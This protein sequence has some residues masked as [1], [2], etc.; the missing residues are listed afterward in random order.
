[1]SEKTRKRVEPCSRRPC[2][3]SV[4]IVTSRQAPAAFQ[5]SARSS[6]TWRM[7]SSAADLDAG[8]DTRAFLTVPSSADEDSSDWASNC[9]QAQGIGGGLV[10][11]AGRRQRTR[12]SGT[13]SVLAVVLLM[14][15]AVA[16]GPR[17]PHTDYVDALGRTGGQS[18][19]SNLG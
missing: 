8:A 17:R 1:M 4:P 10:E 16:C 5:A 13:A 2:S 6:G 9:S 14:T 11:L 3:S 19:E 7:A 12:R 18:R 15:M